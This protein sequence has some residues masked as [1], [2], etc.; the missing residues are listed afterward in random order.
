ML[1][2][3]VLYFVNFKRATS[4]KSY[5]QLWFLSIKDSYEQDNIELILIH[6]KLLILTELIIL[7]KKP[8]E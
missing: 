3:K 8:L 7:S 4:A 2:F 5:I 6:W 1:S